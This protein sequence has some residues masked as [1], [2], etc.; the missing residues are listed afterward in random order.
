M[1]KSLN[2]DVARLRVDEEQDLSALIR[3]GKQ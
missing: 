3:L 2:R 1:P